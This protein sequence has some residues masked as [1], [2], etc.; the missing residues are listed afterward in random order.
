VSVLRRNVMSAALSV[1]SVDID[2]YGLGPLVHRGC[3]RSRWNSHRENIFSPQM[4]SSG[5][6]PSGKVG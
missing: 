3:V 4:I 5:T 2:E 6:I 1:I